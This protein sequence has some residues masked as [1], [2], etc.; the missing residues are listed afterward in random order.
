MEQIKIND[1]SKSYEIVNQDNKVVGVFTFNPSDAN[2]VA[3]YNKVIEEMD[4][5]FSGI[6]E[7][8]VVTTDRFVEFQDRIKKS[9][10]DLVCQDTAESFFAVTGPLSPLTNGK[11]YVEEVME[12][13]SKIIEKETSQR[14]KKVQTRMDKYLQGYKKKA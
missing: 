12:A 2:I 8:D 10:D 13:I 14:M 3:R 1:G 11:I 6:D 5:Y 9:V 7:K 4:E